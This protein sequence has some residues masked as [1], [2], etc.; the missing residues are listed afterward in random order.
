MYINLTVVLSVFVLLVKTSPLDL[1]CGVDT[2]ERLFT[3]GSSSESERKCELCE[4]LRTKLEF[5]SLCQTNLL[6]APCISNNNLPLSTHHHFPSQ[7]N[8]NFNQSDKDNPQNSEVSPQEQ[9]SI[10]WSKSVP[11]TSSNTDQPS[12]HVL[13]KRLSTLTWMVIRIYVCSSFY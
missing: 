6:G 8:T 5:L 7:Q 3:S 12:F 1:E 9:Q 10:Q 2:I 4:I 11:S 13:I